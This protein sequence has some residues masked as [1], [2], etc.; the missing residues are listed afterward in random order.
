MQKNDYFSSPKGQ[1]SKSKI[2]SS[3]NLRSI[4]LFIISIVYGLIISFVIIMGEE[5]YKSA[6]ML[7][8][9]AY[10]LLGGFGLLMLNKFYSKS[11][12]K[13]KVLTEV[14]EQ[15]TEARIITDTKGKTVYT[16]QKFQDLIGEENDLSLEGFANAFTNHKDI[17]NY[18]KDL[19]LEAAT[20]TS[21][22]I[23]IHAPKKGKDIWLQITCQYIESYIQWRMEDVTGRHEMEATIDE[24][25]TKLRDFTDNAPVGFFSVNENGVFIFANET[26][27]DMLEINSA[28]L[29]GK[30]HLHEF[31]ETIPQDTKPYECFK[32]QSKQQSGEI[33]IKTAKG[34]IFHASIAHSITQTANNA[35]ITRSV[36]YD[37]TKEQTMRKALQASEDRFK[38]L[39]EETP[40]GICIINKDKKITEINHA[41]V[42]ILDKSESLLNNS[43]F[44]DHIKEEYRKSTEDWLNNISTKKDA[45]DG[46]EVA[47]NCSKEVIVQIYANKFHSEDNLVVHFINLTERK[48]LEKQFN[49]SQKMQAVGQLAGGIAHDFNN[50]LTAMIGFADLLLL[51]HKPGD[52]SFSD[53]NQIKQNANRASN[54]VKQLLAFSRQQTLKA[55]VLDLPDVLSELSHLLRRLIGVNIELN[56]SHE[57]N[58][59]IVKADQGQIEQVLINLV[60]NSRDAM[61]GGGVI[62]LKTRSF[63]SDKIIK[64]SG[65]ET[66]P[67]GNWVVISVEDTGTGITPEVLP[68]IFEPFFSTK[69]IGAGTGLGLAT[70]HGIVYQTGGRVSVTSIKGQ[71]TTFNIYLPQSNPEEETKETEVVTVEEEKQ[72]MTDLTGSA[73]ILLV[74]DEDAVRIFSARALTN[75]GYKVV[76]VSGG[77]AALK[78]L[79]EQKFMPDILITDVMMPE[80]DGTTLAK[81]VAKNYPQIKIIFMSGYAEDKFKEQVGGNAYFLPKPFSLKQLAYKVKEV[82]EGI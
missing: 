48:N 69:P 56:I 36:V 7:A 73:S 19:K 57:S 18:L 54:M 50:L 63:T 3:R 5:G 46:L 1:T 21:S 43:S 30:R 20:L 81:I 25:R 15:S 29:I 22:T 9:Y 40:I 60:V 6:S 76:D 51:R 47:L 58:E 44:L 70:V 62:N 61:P 2:L 10:G 75:K 31:L 26:M 72:N 35:I 71:G 45:G 8:L 27:L 33:F 23:E 12:K 53:I 52:P 66:L 24:E 34:K 17:E 14:L 59:A 49:Q 42:T 13:S 16:N 32:S 79:E 80:M 74:E 55:R 82:I 38:R 67:A 77:E 28:G 39:F 37:L 65:E 78:V 64:L 4:I 68:H 11:D 41:L